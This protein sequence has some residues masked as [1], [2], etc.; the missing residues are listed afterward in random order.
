MNEE[1]VVWGP[2]L[3]VALFKGACWNCVEGEEK[4]FGDALPD[5]ACRDAFGGDKMEGAI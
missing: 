4:T 5:Y 2:E 3:G 1:L